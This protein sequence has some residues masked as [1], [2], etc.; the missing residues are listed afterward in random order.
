MSD[1]KEA[2]LAEAQK[3]YKGFLVFLKYLC[4]GFIAIIIVAS[5]NNWGVDG[6][7]SRHLPEEIIDQYDPQNLNKKKGI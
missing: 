4:Y 7:G 6:T 5:F 3:T 1:V 2:A